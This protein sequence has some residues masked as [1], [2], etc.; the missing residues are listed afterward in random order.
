MATEPPLTGPVPAE[1]DPG[2]VPFHTLDTAAAGSRLDVAPDRGLSA[3]EAARRLIRHGPNAIE[4]QP[5]RNIGGML[6][7]Q[8]ADFMILVLTFPIVG[9]FSY[10]THSP[11]EYFRSGPTA[12]WALHPQRRSRSST[13][14]WSRQ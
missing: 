11:G 3:A 7:A 1:G 8:C 4:E 14:N 10:D 2:G 12:R 9:V 13:N 5:R 6:L